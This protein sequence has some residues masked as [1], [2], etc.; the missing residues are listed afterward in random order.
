MDTNRPAAVDE[1]A[2]ASFPANVAPARG[3]EGGAAGRAVPGRSAAGGSERRTERLLTEGLFAG[4]IGYAVLALLLMAAS[5]VDGRSPFYFAAL[6]GTDLFYGPATTRDVAIAAGPV[7]AY[8][9]VHLLVFLLTG[10]F[11]AWLAGL[12]ERAP[13]GWYLMGTLFVFVVAHVLA[14]PAWFHAPVREALSLWLVVGS[15][16]VAAA[17]MTAYLWRAHP[18]LRASMHEPDE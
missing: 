11:M 6:L 17:A 14:V 1:A 3:S 5:V 16:T 12:A 7:F 15:T 10:V 2:R 8:N 13:Q 9:G 4:L 18:G